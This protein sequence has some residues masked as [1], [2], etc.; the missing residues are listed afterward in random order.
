[1]GLIQINISLE[2]IETLVDS[3]FTGSVL[4]LELK[5]AMEIAILDGLVSGKTV[6]I[7]SVFEE[8]WQE[9]VVIEVDNPKPT[10]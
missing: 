6:S 2:F 7:R 9:L 4:L 10:F 3:N 5:D 1:M 8:A